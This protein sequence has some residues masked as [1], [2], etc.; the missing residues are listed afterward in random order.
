MRREE[1]RATRENITGL[2]RMA[3]FFIEKNAQQNSSKFGI[4]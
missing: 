1:F 2:K 4:N 3:T